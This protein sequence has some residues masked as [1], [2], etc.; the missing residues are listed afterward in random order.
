MSAGQQHPPVPNLP[1][2]APR[3]NA[4]ARREL[5]SAFE[6][7][8]REYHEVRPGYPAWVT[9]FVVP[10]GAADAADIGAGTGLFT[11]DLV[12]AGLNVFAVEPSASMRSVLEETLPGVVAIDGTGESTGL[13]AGSVDLVSVAQAWHWMDPAEA[14]TEARRILRPGGTLALIWN[15]LDVTVP[16]VHRLSRIMHAGDVQRNA[17]AAAGVG[18]GFGAA[19]LREEAWVDSVTPASL[20]ELCHSR[21]YYL[22]ASEAVRAKVDANLGWYLYEHLGHAPGELL[23][24]PYSAL[25][26]RFAAR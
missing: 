21:S 2:G 25:A 7:A 3:L 22:R 13:P 4:Q 8:G 16:W 20:F 9:D 14:S 19:E 26:V 1:T 23:E 12:A 5:G 17:L 11:R 6:T 24:L 18:E 10:D 15:Q